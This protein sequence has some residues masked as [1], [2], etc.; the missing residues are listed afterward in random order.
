MGDSTKV[1]QRAKAQ[2]SKLQGA[3]LLAVGM[4]R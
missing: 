3:E 1:T 4:V 2:P